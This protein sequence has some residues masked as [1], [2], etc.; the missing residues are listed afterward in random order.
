MVKNQ[1]AYCKICKKE[2][3][4]PI[5]RQMDSMEKTIWAIIILATLGFA[6]IP[7]LIYRGI[8][9]KKQYCPYC[10]Q[11]LKFSEKPLEKPEKKKKPRTPKEK[12]LEKIKKEEEPEEAEEI[13]KKPKK[14]KPTKAKV[15]EEA[16]EEIIKI[17]PY[18]GQKLKKT[19][20]LKTCPYCK[21]AL[22]F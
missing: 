7:F 21:A 3:D 2:V 20:G 1:Y 5:K 10:G 6:L 11:K 12:V 22:K 15:E 13:E 17:C 9:N 14:K 19:K 8:I 16:E 4:R 18:C